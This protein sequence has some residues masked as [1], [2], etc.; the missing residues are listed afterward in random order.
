[1]DT[2]ELRIKQGAFEGNRQD[3]EKKFKKDEKKRQECVSK[4]SLE[5][6]RELPI[7]RYVVGKPDSFCYWLET[8]L[9]GLGSIKGGSPADKKFGVYYGKTKH[10]STI[11]YRFIGKWGST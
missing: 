10:D 11:K 8:T 7:E 5:K 4:F 1:M 3:L 6:L 2:E 9:R